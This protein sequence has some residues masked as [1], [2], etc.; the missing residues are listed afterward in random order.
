MRITPSGTRKKIEAQRMPD[1]YDPRF[2]IE[3]DPISLNDASDNQPIAKGDYD[4]IGNLRKNLDREMQVNKQEAPKNDYSFSDL[5]DNLSGTQPS[6]NDMATSGGSIKIK[7]FIDKKLIDLG[8]PQRK[9][10]EHE[11]RRFQYNK[12]KQSGFFEVPE[13]TG[14]G[15]FVTE[16]QVDQICEDIQNQFDLDTDWDFAGGIFKVTFSPKQMEVK[17]DALTSWDNPQKATKAAFSKNSLIKESQNNIIN[18]LVKQGFGGKNAS[19][20]RK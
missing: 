3:Q 11:K 19:S 9:L 5:Q 20:S 18:S 16:D 4:P 15:D 12:K 7:Q 14:T 8:I 10:L 1:A 17:Q 13:R 2:S 6:D